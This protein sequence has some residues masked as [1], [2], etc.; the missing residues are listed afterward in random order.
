MTIS[1][2]AGAFTILDWMARKDCPRSIS[3]CYVAHDFASVDFGH[4]SSTH[5]S[6]SARDH[7]TNWPSFRPLGIRPASDQRVIVREETFTVAATSL[8]SI[9]NGL[10]AGA[11]GAVA[12]CIVN[13]RLIASEDGEHF[14]RVTHSV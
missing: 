8:T 3:G 10:S 11:R 4:P 6:I 13:L 14:A 1:A 2:P 12:A 7:L 5:F 9:I